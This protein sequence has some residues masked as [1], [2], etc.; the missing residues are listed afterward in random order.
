MFVLESYTVAVF[1][2]VI[3]ML[4]WGSWANTQKLA[5]KS[6]SFQ[7]FYW[8]YAL[9]VLLLSVLFGLTLG[10][11]GDEGRSVLAD[12]RQASSGAVTSPAVTG[13]LMLISEPETGSAPS[14]VSSSTGLLIT[15]WATM[16]VFEVK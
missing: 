9:G 5:S 12:L 4:C 6:W 8:D 13:S 10:S 11:V 2:C 3:T 1:F 16:A 7:L 15:V 14:L